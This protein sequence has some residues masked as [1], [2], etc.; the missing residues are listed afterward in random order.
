MV[1]ATWSELDQGNR[2]DEAIEF[3]VLLDHCTATDHSSAGTHVNCSFD[4]HALGSEQLSRG[5]FSNNQFLLTVGDG[6]VVEW[7]INFTFGT[8]GFSGQMWEPF[9]AWV[10]Q[11]YPKDIPRMIDGNNN[12]RP[13]ATSIELW[14]KHI[15]DYIAAKSP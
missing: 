2:A 6:K 8:N 5:P 4:V 7:Q 3:R 10:T 14:H 15:A 11:H 1:L 9:V 12:A 13:D